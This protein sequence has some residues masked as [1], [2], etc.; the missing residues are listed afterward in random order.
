MNILAIPNAT[1]IRVIIVLSSLSGS[2]SETT[3]RNITTNPNQI[4]K[5]ES[6]IDISI[7]LPSSLV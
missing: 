1:N 6:R 7:S 4:E 2:C 3:N 5:K